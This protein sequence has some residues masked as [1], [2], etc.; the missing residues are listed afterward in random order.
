[1][2]DINLA[3]VSG[4]RIIQAENLPRNPEKAVNVKAV[5]GAR[6]VLA[7]G[8]DLTAPDTVSVKRVGNDLHLMLQGEHSAQPNLI[9]EDY[10]PQ[11]GEIVGLGEDGQWHAFTAVSADRAQDP[12][13]LQDGEQSTAALDSSVLPPMDKLEVDGNALAFGMIA[14][15]AAAA[16]A[17]L[18]VLVHNNRNHHSSP[19]PD[20]KPEEAAVNPET[21]P[22][23]ASLNPEVT[24]EQGTHPLENPVAIIDKLQDDFGEQ[25]GALSPNDVTDD[26]TPTLNGSDQQSGSVIEIRDNGTFLG[27]AIADSKG[28]WSFTPASPLPDGTHEFVVIATDPGGL[29][30]APSDPA[31]IVIA[32]NPTPLETLSLSDLLP[33][34]TDLS[35]WAHISAYDD[36]GTEHHI[37]APADD[38]SRVVDELLS[39]HPLN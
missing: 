23:A 33:P 15:A 17:A 11:Q 20:E 35:S 26:T 6:Y 18:A 27:T 30:S 36:A 34:D 19:P 31:V 14:L 5:K 3:I 21:Q 32:A 4:K 16:V 1:M 38:A 22:D 24:S 37:M 9:I 39:G 8:D 12:Q 10:Y 13:A 29:V 28:N 7:E 2:D 25:Q